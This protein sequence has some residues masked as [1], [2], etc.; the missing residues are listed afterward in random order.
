M[1]ANAIESLNTILRDYDGGRAVIWDSMR[2]NSAVVIAVV[3]A[4]PSKKRLFLDGISCNRVTYQPTWQPTEIR[5]VRQGLAGSP[6]RIFDKDAL[7]IDC[8]SARVSVESEGEFT[9]NYSCPAGTLNPVDF[10]G[11]LCERYPNSFA[12]IVAH[13]DGYVDA[14]QNHALPWNIENPSLAAFR[15]WIKLKLEWNR[16]T[17]GWKQPVMSKYPDDADAAKKFRQLYSEFR[18]EYTAGNITD[19]PPREGYAT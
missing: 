1:D 19:P 6:I 5:I 18:V 15:E 10:I 12:A 4:D 11:Q 3:T 14:L 17:S 2:F 13:F 8:K 9:Q 16:T 7:R